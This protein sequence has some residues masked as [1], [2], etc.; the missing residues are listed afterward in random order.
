M[1]Q[2]LQGAGG[3]LSLVGELATLEKVMP[4]FVCNAHFHEKRKHQPAY[5]LLLPP[6][7]YS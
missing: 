3:D 1:G 5:R 6:E 7:E 4:G 2:S